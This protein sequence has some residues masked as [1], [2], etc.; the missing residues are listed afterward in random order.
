MSKILPV[1]MLLGLGGSVAYFGAQAFIPASLRVEQQAQATIQKIQLTPAQPQPA[2]PPP[3]KTPAQQV[4]QNKPEQIVVQRNAYLGAAIA[5]LKT[6]SDKLICARAAFFQQ[7]ATQKQT[8]LG[9]TPEQFLIDLLSAKNQ[10]LLTT[11]AQT[12][13]FSGTANLQEKGRSLTLDALAIAQAL[14][15]N[16]EG[17]AP[18]CLSEPYQAGENAQN[19]LIRAQQYRSEINVTTQAITTGASPDANHQPPK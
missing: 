3:D 6:Q 10:E 5:A 14:Q 7:L 4:A 15:N 2:A 8:E 11:A 9:V 18:T 19:Y 16:Y 17:Q 13:G 1:A 12:G